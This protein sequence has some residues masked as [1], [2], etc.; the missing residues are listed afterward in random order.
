MRMRTLLLVG[1]PLLWLGTLG[2]AVAVIYMRHRADQLS[3]QLSQERAR[4]ERL[5]HAWGELQIEKRRRESGVSGV[6]PQ[7]QAPAGETPK[8]TPQP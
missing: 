1:V 5:E 3:F 6:T 7:P 8:E 2:S 4:H